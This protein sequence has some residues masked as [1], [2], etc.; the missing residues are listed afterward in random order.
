MILC[1]IVV[2]WLQEI[3]TEQKKYRD[4]LIEIYCFT[5]RW[6]L[7][8]YYVKQYLFALY[9]YQAEANAWLLRIPCRKR[10]QIVVRCCVSLF[11]FNLLRY[12]LNN[13]GKRFRKAYGVC[14][15]NFFPYV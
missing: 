4:I 1:L 13:G 6:N 3:Y 14:S 9:N 2:F 7:V 5:P 11:L 15:V 12:Y 8:L 10:K